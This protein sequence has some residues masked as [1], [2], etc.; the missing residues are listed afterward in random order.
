MLAVLGWRWARI[1]RTEPGWRSVLRLPRRE[2]ARTADTEALLMRTAEH[3]ARTLAEPPGR[4]QQRWGRARW[5]VA[6]RRAIPLLACVGVVAAAALVPRL[7]LAP[8]AGLR[9]FIFNLP[10]LLLVLVFWLPELPRIELPR[11]PR[12]LAASAWRE[13]RAGGPGALPHPDSSTPAAG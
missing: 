12:R 9:M 8:D 1:D 10:P 13:P 5:A 7:G 3:L 6:A 11:W 2:P 4:F